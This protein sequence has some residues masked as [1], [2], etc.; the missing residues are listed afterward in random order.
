M[1][2]RI[3]PQ[4]LM[5]C[6]KALSLAIYPNAVFLPSIT[7]ASSS[8]FLNSNRSIRICASQHTAKI[9][10]RLDEK[11]NELR[12]KIATIPNALSFCRVGLTPVIGYLIIKES[13]I[14][15]L[16]LFIVSGTTDWV[17]ALTI[18]VILRDVSLIVGGAMIRYKTIEKPITLVRYF[19]PSISPLQVT[20]TFVSKVNTALQMCTIAGSLAA[21]ISGF[22]DHPFLTYIYFATAATTIYSGFQYAKLTRMKPI[23]KK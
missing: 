21:S 14:I 22:T 15:A 16:A 4:H 9:K 11:Q 19:N 1:F 5:L 6:R 20:P 10:V 18:L 17:L 2:R 3:W 7:F 23:K 8:R 12:S 13:Y